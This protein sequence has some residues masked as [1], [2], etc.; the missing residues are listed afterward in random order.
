MIE[1][2]V[3]VLALMTTMREY[4]FFYAVPDVCRSHQIVLNG[5][6]SDFRIMEINQ[7]KLREAEKRRYND[8]FRKNSLHGGHSFPRVGLRSR[9]AIAHPQ[10]PS[11][12]SEA[13]K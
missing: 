6:A 9:V 8:L 3:D 4:L 2:I 11:S 1:D 10:R 13:R 12:L 5:R 7:A